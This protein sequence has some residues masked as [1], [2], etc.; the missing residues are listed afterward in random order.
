[1]FFKL[2][3]DKDKLKILTTIIAATVV[4]TLL[5]T[6][7][8]AGNTGYGY[9]FGDTYVENWYDNNDYSNSLTCYTYRFG[10]QNITN[11]Y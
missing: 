4:P 1:M 11:C 6:T 7:T 5:A 9:T 8:Q 3:Y 2:V 10:D